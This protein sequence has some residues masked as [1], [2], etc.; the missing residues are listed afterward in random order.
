VEKEKEKR[1]EKSQA[2]KLCSPMAISACIDA[3]NILF[4][5]RSCIRSVWCNLWHRSSQISWR[6]NQDAQMSF[7]VHNSGLYLHRSCLFFR[8]MKR[9]G[10]HEI[11][12]KPNENWFQPRQRCIIECIGSGY[13]VRGCGI[14]R[15]RQASNSHFIAMIKECGNCALC[16][17]RTN[18]HKC[19][20]QMVVASSCWQSIMWAVSSLKSIES[21]YHHCTSS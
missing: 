18:L 13:T 7:Y 5:E 2:G 3:S 11:G 6:N 10:F 21:G 19:L 12:K 14:L 16:R 17:V 9:Y 8:N 20:L 4:L 15:R 1:R